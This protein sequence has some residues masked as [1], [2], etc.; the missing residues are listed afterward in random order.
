M[1]RLK[2]KIP[3]RTINLKSATGIVIANMIGSGVFVTAG[4]IAGKLPNPT[5]VLS[6]WI[7]GG[8]I[9]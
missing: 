9:A 5:W 6:F 7:I 1:T 2:M 4:I 8:I 3:K